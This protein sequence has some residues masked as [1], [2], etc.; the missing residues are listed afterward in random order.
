MKDEKKGKYA[1]KYS[2]RKMTSI[3][4]LPGNLTAIALPVLVIPFIFLLANHGS[5]FNHEI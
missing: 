3:P 1:K 2:A 4:G 5:S